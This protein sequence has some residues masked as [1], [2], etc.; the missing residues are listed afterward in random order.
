[1]LIG[2]AYGVCLTLFEVSDN[3]LL[4]LF[5]KM[6]P[7]PNLLASDALNGVRYAVGLLFLYLLIYPH[8]D[9]RAQPTTCVTQVVRR[10]D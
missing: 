6:P 5:G 8:P 2:A 9:R 7:A 4:P 3:L 1:M 10:A